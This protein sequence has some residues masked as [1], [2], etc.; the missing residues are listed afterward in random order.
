M[1]SVALQ[2]VTLATTDAG[3]TTVASTPLG[4]IAVAFAE[5][6]CLFFPPLIPFII[7]ALL[8]RSLPVVT[9]IRGRIVGPPPPSPL[10]FVPSFLSR[11]E[12]SIFFPLRLALNCACVHPGP[13]RAY[14]E[15]AAGVSPA[16][17]AILYTTTA[18]TRGSYDTK[19]TSM[20]FL[21]DTRS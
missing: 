13:L 1:P 2:G 6:I 12:F 10:R 3:A 7:L 17:R 8:S 18:R 9:Q 11:E 4:S 14:A 20:T 19:T 21:N 15:P 5:S 16:R